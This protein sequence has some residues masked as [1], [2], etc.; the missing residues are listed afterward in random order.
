MHVAFVLQVNR[1][2]DYVGGGTK[3]LVEAK[4][5]QKS[6]RKWCCC[7]I[8]TLLIILIIVFVVVSQ[9][10]LSSGRYLLQAELWAASVITVMC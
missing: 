6:K 4:Q 5:Y 7:A 2:V 1:A 10:N 3:A 9:A 8:I